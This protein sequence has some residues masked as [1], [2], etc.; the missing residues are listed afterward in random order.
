MSMSA[1]KRSG[2]QLH[3]ELRR[4]AASVKG[5]PHPSEIVHELQVYQEELAVQNDMLREAL[6]DLEEARD[7]FIE[8]YDFAPNGYLTLDEHGVILQINLTGASWLGKSKPVLEGMPLLGFIHT[9]DRPSL[10]DFMRKCRHHKEGQPLC[11]DLRVR[12]GDGPRHVQL[13]CRPRAK[14]VHRA[15]EFFTAMVDVTERR[16]LEA[17]REEALQHRAAL[18]GRI[19]GIQEEE[20]H[21][22]A[23]DLHDNIGQQVT[24]LRLKLDAIEMAVGDN[25]YAHERLSE[26][27]TL[28]ATLDQTLDFIA[29]ELRP[30]ALDLGFT[31]ALEQFAADWSRNFGIEVRLQIP[32]AANVRLLPVVE[33]HLYRVAQEALH[34]VYKH[35]NATHVVITLEQRG[36]RFRLVIEDDGV[37]P[38][39]LRD[40]GAARRGLG[41]IGMR[42]RVQL[43]GG[44]IEFT[45]SASGGMKVIA[46]VSNEVPKSV[47]R[48]PW[49]V[50]AVAKRQP[51]KPVTASRARRSTGKRTKATRSSRQRR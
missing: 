31:T 1:K 9:S 19:I 15:R 8:L 10:V 37:G 49:D 33:T 42:E 32:S 34:N 41:L 35:A 7:R 13:L 39:A 36:A 26:A 20:R 45:K 48:M 14:T 3:A 22:I 46:E 28:G 18:A 44:T 21:R 6:S 17:E 25:A 27:Q 43:V 29:S 40:E 30:A 12:S 4:L 5:I 47:P 50:L 16:R 23:R 11:V 24:G 2:K 51:R 38:D